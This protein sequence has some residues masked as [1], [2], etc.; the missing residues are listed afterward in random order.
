M[1]VI[2]SD[3]LAFLLSSSPPS[4]IARVDVT[5]HTTVLIRTATA[6]DAEPGMS[7]PCTLYDDTH[8][9][10]STVTA[11][12]RR[13]PLISRLLHSYCIPTRVLRW[14]MGLALCGMEIADAP[15]WI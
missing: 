15:F 12:P 4:C 2:F 3:L 8:I 14:L 5:D 13:S 11:D 7:L 9:E 10:D 1:H 6:H